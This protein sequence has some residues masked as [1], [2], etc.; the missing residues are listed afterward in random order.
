MPV[1]T[2][3]RVSHLFYNHVGLIGDRLVGG[4]RTVLSFSSK[5][6][7][8]VEEAW[9]AYS[10]RSDVTVEGY[11]GDLPGSVVMERARMKQDVPY[12]MGAFNCEHFVRFAHRVPVES[13]QLSQ[14]LQLA[15]LCSFFVLVLRR[16]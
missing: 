8:F 11:L 1:G 4:E 6:G 16:A 3:V 15:G 14:W 5:F 13:P 7:G 12:S 10:N 2:V 9:S